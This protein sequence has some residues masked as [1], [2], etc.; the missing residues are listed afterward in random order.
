MS[1]I[2]KGDALDR[3]G[4][5]LFA[6]AWVSGVTREEFEAN[7]RY[8]LAM[9]RAPEPLPVDGSIEEVSHAKMRRY[10][11][12]Q[13]QAHRWLENHGF[14]CTENDFDRKAFEAAFT[15]AFP[16]QQTSS[17]QVKL[18]RRPGTRGPSQG[19]SPF[20]EGDR[21]LFP[22][23]KGL[24]RK[25]LNITAASRSLAGKLAGGG[26]PESKAKRLAKRYIDE[27]D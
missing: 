7:Q 25:G 20:A 14:N 16:V 1:T 26:T 24:I 10:D 18:R 19:T 12:Q 13:H 15:H 4:R 3:I 11:E 9:T 2:T 5:A 17:G 23:L 27:T 22:A 21:K 6:G 8:K